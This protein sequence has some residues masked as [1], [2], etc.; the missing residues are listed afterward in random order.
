M[1]F[2]SVTDIFSKIEY[3]EIDNDNFK[4]YLTTGTFLSFSQR[5][6]TSMLS[7]SSSGL[8]SQNNCWEFSVHL[9][10]QHLQRLPGQLGHDAWTSG[11]PTRK[12]SGKDDVHALKKM[13]VLRWPR[14]EMNRSELPPCW[15]PFLFLAS[16]LAPSCPIPSWTLCDKNLQDLAFRTNWGFA[17]KCCPSQMSNILHKNVFQQSR[18]SRWYLVKRVV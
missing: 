6:Q 8:I 18:Q 3:D 13:Y 15:S 4:S 2:N 1:L 12:R 16:A 5:M 11:I 9:W 10:F 17:A 14:F 7:W